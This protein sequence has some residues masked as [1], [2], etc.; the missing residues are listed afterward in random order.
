VIEALA[1]GGVL[2]GLPR[3]LALNLAAQTVVG[4]ATMVRETGEHPAVLRDQVTSPRGD[5]HCGIGGIG[6][7]RITL[8]L[9]FGGPRGDGALPPTPLS[10]ARCCPNCVTV[11]KPIAV[12][13]LLAPVMFAARNPNRIWA[14]A[15][16]PTSGIR[17]GQDFRG[18][19]TA[20]EEGDRCVG[21]RATTI[22]P[23]GTSRK[24]SNSRRTTPRR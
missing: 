4:A 12:A 3:D 18:R 5:D 13:A 10:C 19:S 1:D 23:G 7:R 6:I 15:R 9:D 21:Q 22:P 20:V 8:R 17:Q 14:W 11:L 24:S 16:R 2:M